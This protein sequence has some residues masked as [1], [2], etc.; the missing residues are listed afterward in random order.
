MAVAVPREANVDADRLSHPAQYGNVEADAIGAGLTVRRVQPSA[1]QWLALRHA[2]GVGVASHHPSRR[3][4]RR[5]S[6]PR[7]QATRPSA[8]EA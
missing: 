4:R 8:S 7:P 1:Y 2:S 6:A 3:D 5:G